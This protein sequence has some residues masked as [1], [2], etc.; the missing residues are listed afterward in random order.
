MQ[1]KNAPQR[2]FSSNFTFLSADQGRGG[3][4]RLLA[5]GT[6]DPSFPGQFNSFVSSIVPQF[7]GKFLVGGDFT[8]IGNDPVNRLARL[9]A[10]GSLDVSFDMSK[11]ANDLVSSMALQLDGSIVAVGRFTQFNGFDQERIV[12]IQAQPAVIGGEIEFSA[13]RYTVIEGSS[14]ATIDVRR[15]GNISSAVTVDYAASNGTAT[16]ADYVGVTGKLIFAPGESTKAFTVAMRQDVLV[17]D[18][19]T[20]QLSLSNPSGS[21]VLGGYRQATLILV[22][23]DR[24]PTNFGTVDTAE[25]VGANGPVY[26]LLV[27][28]DGKWLVGGE[29]SAIGSVAR[30]RLARLNANGSVDSSFEPA[31]WFNNTVFALGLQSDGRVLVAG[32]FTKVNGVT[33]N[34][35]A[36]LNSDGSLDTF[37]DPGIGPDS[38][39]SSLLVLPNDDIVVGGAYSMF[40][41]DTNYSYLARLLSDGTLAT[42]FT[43]RVN[44]TVWAIA[45]V[46]TDRIVLGGDFT[47]VR[48]QERPRLASLRLD[49]E[50]VAEFNPGKGPNSTVHAMWTLPDQRVLVGGSFNEYDG[51]PAQ[52]LARVGADGSFDS[53]FSGSTHF[54]SPVWSLVIQPN[55]QI[56]AMGDFTAFDETPQGYV[57]RLTS[58]GELDPTFAIGK[59]ANGQV[60]RG[61]LHPDGHLLLGGSF[62]VFSGLSRPNLVQ[63]FAS[64]PTNT[65]S[66]FIRSIELQSTGEVQLTIAGVAGQKYILQSSPTMFDWTAISSGTLTE[67]ETVI[68]QSI[69]VQAKSLFFRLLGP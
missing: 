58:E 6:P 15:L 46:G 41:N 11:G 53:S 28:P 7:D 23:D 54:N 3:I 10:D 12:R 17:E 36:R 38:E 55:G 40:N 44:G 51:K 45:P 9:L 21:A 34:R 8:A 57:A 43:P 39:I 26:D 59:G 30:L 47:R 68:P 19:E 20:I 60:R 22:N 2:A 62:T 1:A 5:D 13:T 16:A 65:R 56:V 42:T 32:Q 4:C 64:P 14:A 49:G 25:V 24:W 52:Y 69:P 48:G 37:F 66:A 29:F 33:R 50:L 61:V 35:I 27:Q 67:S 63:L 31:T 18:D